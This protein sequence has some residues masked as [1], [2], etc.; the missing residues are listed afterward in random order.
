MLTHRQPQPQ[1]S[2]R[3]PPAQPAGKCNH[4]DCSGCSCSCHLSFPLQVITDNDGTEIFSAIEPEP[5]TWLW[6][7]YL[8]LGEVTIVDGHPG[9]GKSTLTID[10][11]ARISTGRGWPD[12][13]PSP[14]GPVMSISAEDSHSKVV[15]PRLDAAGANTTLVFAVTRSFELVS[16]DLAWLEETIGRYGILAVFID[17]LDDFVP[18]GIDTHRNASV[19]KSM[20]RPLSEL[21]HRMNVAI[22][23][24]RHLVKDGKGSNPMMRGQGSVGIIGA[25][26]HGLM[27]GEDPDDPER[28]VLAVQKASYGKRAPS[29]SFRLVE[30]AP[31]IARVEWLGAST[32]TAQ[33]L[34]TADGAT[35]AG[36]A[37]AF[38]REYLS[39]GPQPSEEI[40]REGK[41][42]GIGRES[43][44]NAKKRLGILARK[45][46]MTGGWCWQLSDRDTEHT[47]ASNPSNTSNASKHSKDSKH[48][49]WK[50]D[51]G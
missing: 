26:R 12:G 37:D 21:A 15:R 43:L 6:P 27:V 34:V 33:S 36:Q 8:P 22:I 45:A 9:A 7:G 44:W 51:E 13:S 46:G 30:A 31:D 50:E 20:M 40:I 25:A 48:T 16:A 29:L 47:H 23:L 11:A 18:A 39:A 17:P 14:D 49:P 3:L 19:R 4:L 41:Q 38:L 32:H 24:V 5:I 2:T 10:I 35:K 42:A 28:R 1:D